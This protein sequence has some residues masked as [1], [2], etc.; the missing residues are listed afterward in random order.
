MISS[1]T[2][3][4]TYFDLIQQCVYENETRVPDIDEMRQH[5]LHV[6]LDRQHQDVD[7]TPCG[8]INQNDRGQR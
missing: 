6:Y 1:A 4:F 5:L 7:R 3:L 8:R 2:Q